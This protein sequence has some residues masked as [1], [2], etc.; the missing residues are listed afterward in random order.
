MLTRRRSLLA[1]AIGVVMVTAACSGVN[2]GAQQQAGDSKPVATQSATGEASGQ[3][4]GASGKSD[5][6]IAWIMS[7]ATAQAD[8]RAVDG[9]KGYIKDKG[10]EW[11]VDVND[12]KGSPAEAA[13]L[14]ENAVQRK[15]DVIILSMVDL[16][17]S[18]AALEQAKSSG[19]PVFT[20]DSGWTEG[21]IVDVTSNN[22]VMS[23]LVSSYL[24]DRLGG[25]GNIVAF[26]ENTHHGV[27]KRGETLD[28]VV[29]ENPG[30]K[31]VDEHNIDPTNFFEDTQKAM[32]DFLTRHGDNIDAVWAGWDEPAQAAANAIQAAGHG[33][34]DIFVV[35]IDGHPSAVDE[36]RK[37]GPFV[38][39][40]AQAFEKMGSLTGEYITAIVT[41]GKNPKDVVPST[42][43]YLDAP[44]IIPNNLP[45]PGVLPWKVGEN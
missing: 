6:N 35:G 44:L 17:A 28:V 2:S 8:N 22:Y 7:K 26:K 12:A 19:I 41:E 16:R 42:T 43:V 37:G 21:V 11:K 1:A 45:E 29:K 14:L 15:S 5:L 31:I 13:T 4:L 24:V 18:K 36:I 10:L 3:P 23:G 9:F 38:A 27:R 40:V 30:I 20:I 33:R 32:E 39:T 34:D 25:K